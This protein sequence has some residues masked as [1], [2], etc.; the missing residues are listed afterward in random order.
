MWIILGALG[1]IAATLALTALG[2][3]VWLR[4]SLRWAD[5][6]DDHHGLA[7]PAHRS[8]LAW[9]TGW[10]RPKHRL[11]TYRRDGRGRFRKHRR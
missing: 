7:E 2:A 8:W 10:A 11:L 9:L 5:L 1:A 3:L 4:R 6:E